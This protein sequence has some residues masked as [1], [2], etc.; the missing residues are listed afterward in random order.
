MWKNALIPFYSWVFLNIII[1][2]PAL[3][4]LPIAAFQ[5]TIALMILNKKKYVKMGLIGGIIFLVAIA[6]LRVETLPNL[7]LS[8]AIGLLLR[9]EFNTTFLES[10]RAK[11]R[12]Q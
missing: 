7:I 2:N 9:R 3:F 12:S 4:V 10:I 8:A 6:P 5:I 11:F 1:L